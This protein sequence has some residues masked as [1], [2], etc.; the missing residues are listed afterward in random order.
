MKTLAL[1]TSGVTG[2][3]A[4]LDGGAV[5]DSI[6]LSQR[7]KTAQLL[8]PAMRDLLARVGWSPGDVARVAVTVGPGSFTGLRIGV[9]TAKTFAY[10]VGA[11]VIGVNTLEV[12]AEGAP[13]DCRRLEVVLDAQ[14]REVFAGSFERDDS[15]VMQWRA[16]THIVAAETW[17]QSLCEGDIVS[18]PGLEKLVEQLPPGVTA[19]DLA[20]WT[21]TVAALGQLA[22]RLYEQGQRDDLWQLVPL[23]FRR[24]AAEEKWEEKEREKGQKRS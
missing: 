9:T 8:A 14:R 18:G 1:E 11:E 21:P 2:G 22:H 23:Y 3:V 6:S 16:A 13:E 7:A 4:V 17:L 20:C 19:L 15:G 5:L 12:I 24:S 10:A